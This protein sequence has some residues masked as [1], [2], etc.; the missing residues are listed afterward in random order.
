MRRLSSQSAATLSRRVFR[1]A[2]DSGFQ[3][4]KV[5]ITLSA[6]V[7]EQE[8]RFSKLL[9]KRIDTPGDKA[10]RLWDSQ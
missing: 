8:N 2:R 5:P 7:L 1:L 9:D 3:E 4:E 6:V 10:L